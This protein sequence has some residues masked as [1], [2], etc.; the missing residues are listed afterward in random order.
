[1][2][3][4]HFL[5]PRGCHPEKPLF[6]FLT[7]MDGTGELF[8]LQTDSLATAFDIRCLKIPPDDFSDWNDLCEQVIALIKEELLSNSHCSVYIC[9]ESFG[10]CL[11]LQVALRSPPQL[12]SHLVLVNPAT[13]FNKSPW[14]SLGIPIT[15]I[16]PEV[17]YQ[18][19]T[20]VLLPYLVVPEKVSPTERCALL[21][22]M[23][24]VPSQ[25]SSWRLSLMKT[26]RI[27]AH[28]LGNLN[29]QLLIVA[30][31]RDRILPSVA[32]AKRLVRLCPQ[33][34]DVVLP[35]SGHACLLE[36]DV[37]LYEILQGENLI[38]HDLV[39]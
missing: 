16:M 1:M 20:A 21:Y 14:L 35:T 23:K 6:V 10:G 36:Q 22:A 30:G 33:A 27:E 32:E 18:A 15:A 4:L 29:Q 17:I 37:N 12:V 2:A 26:F 8:Y 39:T 38:T 25:N 19:S 5:K 11:A 9:G 31:T 3:Q 34:K 7:G 13:S 28:S 24:S